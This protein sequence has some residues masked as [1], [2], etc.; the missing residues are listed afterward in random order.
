MRK[1]LKLLI[2]HLKTRDYRWK[3]K[4]AIILPVFVILLAIDLV[5]KQLA[6]AYLPFDKTYNFI[7]DVIV[8]HRVNNPGIA[9]GTNL[10]LSATIAIAI[11]LVIITTLAALYINLMLVS[12]GFTCIATGA[13][14]NLITRIWNHGTVVDFIKWTLTPSSVIFNM[15]DVFVIMGCVLI[16]FGLIVEMFV[17]YAIRV[18]ENKAEDE[19][20]AKT[21]ESKKTNEKNS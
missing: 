5:T 9:F 14:G 18:R 4:L 19:R 13:L 20:L 3:I 12:V 8:L 2:N 11:I 6:V 21:A 16:G 10:N 15:A 7:G 1:Q 17:A